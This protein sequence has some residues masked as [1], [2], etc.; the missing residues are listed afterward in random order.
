M[1]GLDR[2]L[3]CL[4]CAL[5]LLCYLHFVLLGQL[6][7]GGGESW[8]WFLLSIFFTCSRH[9]VTGFLVTAVHERAENGLW[10]CLSPVM[11]RTW[12]HHCK[13]SECCCGYSASHS[14]AFWACINS[15]ASVCYAVCHRC[16]LYCRVQ[17]RT[18]LEIC[19]LTFTVTWE[20]CATASLRQKG[21][22]ILTRRGVALT[23]GWLL[24]EHTSCMQ[25]WLVFKWTVTKSLI[26]ENKWKC[27]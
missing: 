4:G 21:L 9:W 23:L 25:G 12:G 18:V 10:W 1:V 24:Y 16:L 27:F 8:H 2:F 15:R 3:F 7:W 14:R 13:S 11:Y 6:A 22:S 20:D 26:E 19:A 17:T 5:W